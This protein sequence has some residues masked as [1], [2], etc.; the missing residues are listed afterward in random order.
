M[1]LYIPEIMK[2][3]KNKRANFVEGFTISNVSSGLVLYDLEDLYFL[4]AFEGIIYHN[5]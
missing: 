5:L 1:D 4:C 3:I 2:N